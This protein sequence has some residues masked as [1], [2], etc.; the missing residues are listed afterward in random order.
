[1]RD[2]YGNA[3]SSLPV[4]KVGPGS[5][6]MEDFETIK[7]DFDGEDSSQTFEISLKMRELDRNDRSIIQYDF[8]EDEVTL[9]R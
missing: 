5:K 8:G 7:R 4:T 3:F 9:T 1:M 2:R 6:F